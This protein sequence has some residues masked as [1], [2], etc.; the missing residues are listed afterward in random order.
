MSRKTIEGFAIVRRQFGKR[1]FEVIGVGR[2][3]P[4]AW[5]DAA[6]SYYRTSWVDA[7]EMIARHPEMKSVQAKITVTFD[8]PEGV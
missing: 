6:S 2:D 1:T 7:K 8:K 4:E 5:R 3:T